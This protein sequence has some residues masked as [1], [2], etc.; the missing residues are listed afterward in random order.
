MQLKPKSEYGIVAVCASPA[1]MK[2]ISMII[3]YHAL[4]PLGIN[5]NINREVRLLHRMYQGTQMLDLNH[6]CFSA[7]ILLL[8]DYLNSDTTLG[9]MLNIALD[10]FIVDTGLGGEVFNMDFK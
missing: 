5:Q 10:T 6:G 7:K 1:K 9:K 3:H 4:S 8:R 2:K